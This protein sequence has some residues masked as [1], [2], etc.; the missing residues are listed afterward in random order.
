L[1]RPPKEGPTAVRGVVVVV[2]RRPL[3]RNLVRFILQ[4]NGFEVAAEAATPAE[5]VRLVE[6]EHPAV[7]VL[8]ENAAWERGRPTIPLLRNTLPEGKLLVIASAFGV[9]RMDLVRDADAVLEEGV[10]FKNLPSVV[11]R[12]AAGAA[13]PGSGGAARTRKSAPAPAREK[14]RWL[15][16]VQ[17]AT[18][19]SVVFLALVIARAAA[20]PGP[21]AV[22]AR[23]AVAL[24]AAV[25]SLQDL[26]AVSTDSPNDVIQQA[27]EVAA[28]RAAAVDAGANVSALDAQIRAL[29]DDVLPA[30]PDD[31]AKTLLLVFADVQ[32]ISTPTPTPTPS[33][34]PS[35]PAEPGSGPPPG[36]KEGPPPTPEIAAVLPPPSPSEE[37]TPTATEE[38][39][40]SPIEEPPGHTD[41]GP[42]SDTPSPSPSETVTETPSPIPTEQP[43]PR[44]D[45]TDTPSASE[46]VAETA[47]PT[48]PVTKTPS[49]SQTVTETPSPSQ[50]VTETPSPSETV[51][52]TPSPSETVTDTPSPSETVTSTTPPPTE[53]GGSVGAKTDGGGSV[54]VLVVPPWLGALAG[55]AR[56]RARRARRDAGG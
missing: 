23:P 56:R 34:T 3:E 48:E 7:V 54:A 35:P 29:V 42:P 40:P 30:L 32:G 27:I 44:P 19:A 46:T 10:G 17:G 49:P 4:E 45:P 41:H 51:T 1:K 15:D 47:T 6:R 31:A 8:H 43:P 50:T 13:A 55:V 26:Q 16:R 11:G 9:V 12:L 28:D 37:P 53:T 52:E 36:S 24:R 21:E 18:A 39:E 20:P 33:P 38:P 22:N 14:E 5:A 2:D 25:H